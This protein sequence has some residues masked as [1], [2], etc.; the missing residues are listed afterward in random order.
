MILSS[1]GTVP[2]AVLKGEDGS[3]CLPSDKNVDSGVVP[4]EILFLKLCPYLNKVWLAD[5]AGAAP[6]EFFP[7]IPIVVSFDCLIVYLRLKQVAKVMALLM[8]GNMLPS[9]QIEGLVLAGSDFL[10]EPCKTAL[11]PWH[12]PSAPKLAS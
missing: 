12:Y 2:P 6:T 4:G 9:V 5:F 11:H 3:Y 1:K 8:T 10:R 7:L